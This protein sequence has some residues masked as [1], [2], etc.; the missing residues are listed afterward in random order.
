MIVVGSFV[1]P[2]EEI[3][4]R[5]DLVEIVSAYVALKKSGRNLLGLCPFH[6]EK[7]PSFNVS[8]DRQVWKCYGCGEGGDVFSFVQKIESCTFPEAV[9][10]LAQKAGVRIQRS[11]KTVR[12]LGERDRLLF[13]NNAACSFFQAALAKSVKA[14]EY[15]A[16]RAISQATIEKYRLGYAPDA[17]EELHNHL[18]DKSVNE[19]DAAKAGLIIR[20]DNGQGCYDRFRDRLIFPIVDNSDRIIGF[21]GRALGDD[22]AKY[23]NSPE[24]LLFVK[25]RTLYGL[26]FARRAIVDKERVIVVEGYFDA[27][28]AQEAGFENTVATM[29]TA[30]TEEHVNIIARFTKNV[31]LAFDADSAGMSAALRSWPIFERAGFSVRILS[32]PSGEDPDSL[33]RTGDSSQFARLIQEAR[34]MPD[35]RIG[36]VMSKADLNSEDGRADALK[37]GAAVIAE[38]DSPVERER[39]VRVLSRYHPNFATGTSLAEDHVRSEVMRLRHRSSK[40]ATSHAAHQAPDVTPKRRKLSLIEQS[41]KRILGILILRG[42]DASKVFEA[43]PPN[44]F[45]G[46]GAA[47]LALA[48][49]RQISELG[50][51]DQE[52]LRSDVHNTP[53]EA[54]LTD[55]LVESDDVELDHPL[56]ALVNSVLTRRSFEQRLRMRA[57]AQKIQ[58]GVIKRGSEE[59]EEYWRLAQTKTQGS[60]WR[61]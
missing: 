32:M 43:L 47:A 46:D 14:R 57:L 7:T 52:V 2:L 25:N 6:S 10:R 3:R 29:G 36:L 5:C 61:R 20:R 55:I 12:E 24:T 34:P 27:I 19:Q 9:E 4:T 18:L 35:Y 45:M 48:V 39:L 44:Q 49:N 54:L 28:A 40:P 26:N 31:V 15:L 42:G 56:D 17:W 37:A 22:P 11:E 59:F 60:G 16:D 1:Y 51:I 21:G 58:E 30:L 38:V 13:A 53:A 50:K 41:E 33:L 8:P 23:L